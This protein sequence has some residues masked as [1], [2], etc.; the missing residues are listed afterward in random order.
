[1]VRK[2]PVYSKDACSKKD[3]Q[4][5]SYKRVLILALTVLLLL[6]CFMPATAEDSISAAEENNDS[7]TEENSV[8]ATDEVFDLPSEEGIDALPPAVDYS[9][10]CFYDF[11]SVPVLRDDNKATGYTFTAGQTL[12]VRWTENIPVRFV[13]IAFTRDPVPFTLNQYDENGTLLKTEQGH[14]MLNYAYA[15]EEGS[16]S[17][18]IVNGEQEMSLCSLYMYGEGTVPDFHP[19]IEPGDKLDYM[20]VATH[21]DDDVLFLGAVAPIYGVER[22][23]QGTVIFLAASSRLRMDEGLNGAWAMG[24]WLYPQFSP[25]RD[26]QKRTKKVFEIDQVTEYLVRQFR[27]YRPDLVVAQDPNGEYHHWQHVDGVIAVRKA[28][29]LAADASYDPDSA[30]LYGTWQVKKLYLHLFPENTITLDI[31]APLAGFGGRSAL[32]VAREA[33]LCHKSQRNSRHAGK[34]EGVY[35]ISAFGLAFT[36]VGPDTPGKNDM[37]ENIE[38]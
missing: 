26:V 24:I 4:P 13:Y 14:Q 37:F 35:D 25:F 16:R 31:H 28:V 38:A 3:G 23:K 17:L 20:I 27:R 12:P 29:E 34:N 36:A 2:V 21:C 11:T 8:S 32:E 7:V 33:F 30:E 9:K 1:M 19:F 6:A 22:N 10:N 5:L 18:T 15:L